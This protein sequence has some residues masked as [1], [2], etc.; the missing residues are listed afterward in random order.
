MTETRKHLTLLLLLCAIFFLGNG[1][2]AITDQVESN[3][4]LT[5]KEMLASGDYFSPRIYGEYWYDKPAF[6]YWELIAAFSLFGTTDFAARLFPGIFASIGVFLTYAFG[7]QLYDARTGFF[8][9]G[10][11]ATSLGYWIVAKS[12]ITDATL[13]VFLN[14]SLVFF[15]LGYRHDRRL[16]YASWLFSGLAVL[17]KGP[18]GIVLPGL[19]ILMFLLVRRDI[20]EL[21]RIKPLG[22]GLFVLVGGSWYAGM[23]ALH[24]ADFI[25]NFFGVHN[26][27]RATVAE[28]GAWDVWYFYSAIF[29]VIFFPWS[30]L[31]IL[32]LIRRLRRGLRGGGDCAGYAV[33]SDLGTWCQRILS[34]NGNKILDLYPARADALC[35]T[36]RTPPDAVRSCH[37]PPGGFCRTDRWRWDNAPFYFH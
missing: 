13:F 31:L 7:R 35:P 9:A 24:G 20:G 34:G 22:L 2:L 19:I 21:R 3:Y 14:A 8:A 16:Y 6:F 11:L 12:V 26:V 18:V 1:T 17:T 29:L 32:P 15:Y 4:V 25:S 5:A 30:F 28:H 36:H 10:I 23:Y 27:L 37:A 33:S